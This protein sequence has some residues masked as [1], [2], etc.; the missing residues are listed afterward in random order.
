MRG[1]TTTE[2]IYRSLGQRMDRRTLES[3]V[4]ARSLRPRFSV[5]WIVALVLALLV[6]A[7]TLLLLAGAAF[8]VLRGGVMGLFIGGFLLLLVWVL[9]PRISRIDEAPLPR[10]K[11]PALYGL[12]DRIAKVVGAPRVKIIGLSADFNAYSSRDGWRARPAIVLGVPML[13]A[14]APQERI[15]LLAHELGHMANGDFGRSLVIEAAGTTLAAWHDVLMPDSLTG[16]GDIAGILS[17]PFQLML[18]VLA[19]AAYGGAWLLAILLFQTRQRGEYYADSLAARAA[20][21]SAA[22]AMLEK[23]A[24]A[25]TWAIAVEALAINPKR[26]LLAE[27]RTLGTTPAAELREALRRHGQ[28]AR[29]DVTHPPTLSRLEVLGRRSALVAGVTLTAAESAAIDAELGSLEGQIR[30]RIVDM[31][32]SRF[33]E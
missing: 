5:S 17:V 13:V 1:Q 9:R 4:A 14:L 23:L 7:L 24:L 21:T 3:L 25:R 28:D 31:A 27:M 16:D 6:H 8:S 26:D 2:R 33:Y 22:V 32:G 10:D 18:A 15:A 20:G 11:L 30:T 12:A 29:L 19:K